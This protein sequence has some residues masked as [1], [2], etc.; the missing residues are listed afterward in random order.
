L[1]INYVA[2][3]GKSTEQGA[4]QRILNKKRISQIKDFVL[5]G[6]S[7]VNTFIL[8]WTD[9]DNLPKIKKESLNIP[10]Q[11]RRAQV[12]DG[13]HRISGLQEAVNIQPEIG[14]KEVLISLCI[15]L[16]TQDAAK[17]FL[18]INSEQKPVPKS[19]IYDLFG[20]AVDDKEHAINRATDI[21][22]FLNT[23]DD[24]PFY[25]FVK[26][27]GSPRITGLID[28]AVMV[29]A[30]K[31]HLDKEGVFTLLKLSEIEVQRKI[32]LNFYTALK[33]VYN[34][35]NKLWDKKTENPFIKGAG[36]NG[37]FEFLVE[38]LVPRCQADRNFSYEHMR[39]LMKLDAESLMTSTDLKN[40]DGKTARKNVKAFLNEYFL[41]DVPTST[42]EYEF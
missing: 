19:L 14:E 15:G 23:N 13:Q 34:K 17:I 1:Q 3:R 21:I 5:Q 7:F 11:G 31:P 4:V 39:N 42:D 28:L 38:S 9:V 8:N 41:K 27:P 10:L 16:N 36:F 40:L 33:D 35:S 6:N 30:M 22:E 18:N 24:S 25:Q 2:A 26:Y 20:E 32:I 37:A 12:L 29:N